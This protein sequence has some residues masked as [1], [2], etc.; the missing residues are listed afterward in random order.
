ML[1]VLCI[2]HIKASNKVTM[3]VQN[4]FR[5]SDAARLLLVTG[6][7]G[8][9]QV[10]LPQELI[11]NGFVDNPVLC[12][13]Y[14]VAYCMGHPEREFLM[15]LCPAT[16]GSPVCVTQP[17]T[18]SIPSVSPTISPTGPTVSPTYVLPVPVESVAQAGGSYILIMIIV[19]LAI[20]VIGGFVWRERKARQRGRHKVR[21]IPSHVKNLPETPIKSS[22]SPLE[23]KF[24]KVLGL[25]VDMSNHVSPEKDV[26]S[27]ND[28][29]KV[30]HNVILNAMSRSVWDRRENYREKRSNKIAPI[31]AYDD[32][33]DNEDDE[34]LNGSNKPVLQP[35]QLF[36]AVHPELA[37]AD[38]N[39]ASNTSDTS[40]IQNTTR[41]RI[42]F[43]SF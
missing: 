15:N 12:N 28:N 9:P 19:F 1:K 30:R 5:Y 3:R 29:D 39:I 26:S 38:E 18:T 31:P 14:S 40:P 33:D 4:L 7:L 25:E 24:I 10:G 43:L 32:I 2:A 17:P 22:N 8:K 36:R 34:S 6:L 27:A 35:V 23:D 42:S 16:C 41:S 37:L 13:R 21:D 20:L 11:C